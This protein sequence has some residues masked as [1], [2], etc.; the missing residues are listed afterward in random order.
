MSARYTQLMDTRTY[1]N[2]RDI[3]RYTI[4]VETMYC[5]YKSE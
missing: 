2:T 5:M 1:V 3:F 4:C